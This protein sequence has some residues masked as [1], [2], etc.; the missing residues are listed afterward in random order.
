M[1]SLFHDFFRDPD[2]I[3]ASAL[4]LRSEHLKG[5]VVP[6]EFLISP[7]LLAPVTLFGIPVIVD[8]TL[9]PGEVK[10]VTTP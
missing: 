9:K 7:D 1:I 3:I 6:L 4:K 2:S 10:L 8:S 5:N